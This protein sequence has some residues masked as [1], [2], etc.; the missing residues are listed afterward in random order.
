MNCRKLVLAAAALALLFSAAPVSAA[1]VDQVKFEDR[2]KA[3]RVMLRLQGYGLAYYKVVFKGLAAGLYLDET[4][5][6]DDV[7]DDVA[8]RLEMEY[9][10]SIKAETLIKASEKLL[11]D[12]LSPEQLAVLRP[13]IDELHSYFTDVKPGDRCSLTY[14]PGVGIWLTQ[15]GKIRGTVADAELGKVYFSI[16]VGEKPM[17]AQLKKQLLGDK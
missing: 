17:D 5:Q 15:N 9:F 11:A 16:W 7:M 4:K 2:L 3:G 10:W 14:L 8:K 6:P 13:K 12:N 1:Q